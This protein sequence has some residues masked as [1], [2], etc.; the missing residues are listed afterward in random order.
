MVGGAAGRAGVW[1]EGPHA[2]WARPWPGL[3]VWMDGG[4][5]AP[6]LGTYLLQFPV[7]GCPESSHPRDESAES[8][9]EGGERTDPQ[10]HILNQEGK[11]LGFTSSKP[12]GRKPLWDVGG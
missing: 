10:S 8:Q 4:S 1:W 7:E 5:Q 3:Q 11:Y 12:H 6:G 2:W 9:P